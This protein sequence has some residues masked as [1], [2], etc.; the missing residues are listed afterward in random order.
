MRAYKV[1]RLPALL[2]GGVMA[3]ACLGVTSSPAM[4]QSSDKAEA[5]AEARKLYRDGQTQYD[6]GNFDEAIRLF[7]KAYS[8]SPFSSLLYNIAQSYRQ[9]G[10]CQALFFY[11]RYLTVA[12]KKARNRDN[13]EAHIKELTKTCRAIEELKERPPPGAMPP[14]GEGG[15]DD[16]GEGDGTDGEDTEGG[17]GSTESGSP[18]AKVADASGSGDGDGDWEEGDGDTK[19]GISTRTG[20]GSPSRLITSVELGPAFLDIGEPT[21]G[22]DLG[23]AYFSFGVGAAYPLQFGKVGVDLGA[24]VTFT[25]VP[26]DNT[27]GTTGTAGLTGLLANVGGRYWVMDKLALRTHAGVGVLV[28]SGVGGQSVFVNP[29]SEVSGALSMLNLRFGVGADYLLTRNFVISASP[30]SYS[31]SPAAENLRDG[32]DGFTRIEIFAGLGYRL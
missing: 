25:G 26:W 6:L 28:L 15:D 18:G 13:V 24:L 11:K 22:L 14:D 12:G 17:D 16:D 32:I 21:G 7:K 2:L 23:G 3:V 27:M 1:S 31:Y 9:K 4:A 19:V 29:G 30:F 8:V 20:T 10:D 5:K